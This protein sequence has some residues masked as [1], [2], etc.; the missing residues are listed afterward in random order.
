M[1]KI[2][3]TGASGFIARNIIATLLKNGHEVVGC[4]RN[5]SFVET[6]FPGMKTISADFFIDTDPKIWEARL[7]GVDVVINCVGVF[8]MPNPKDTWA[9]HYDTPKALFEAAESIGVKKIIHISALGI[10]HGKQPYSLSKLKIEDYLTHKNTVDSIILRPSVVYGSGSYG[11]SSLF[12][13]FAGMPFILPLPG[14]AKQQFQPI[15]IEDLARVVHESIDLPGKK[16]LALVGPETITLKSILNALR[17]WLGFKKAINLPIPFFSIRLLAKLGDR[18]T[19]S[20]VN[21]TAVEMMQ[22]DNI[23]TPEEVDE[24]KKSISFAPRGFSQAL[25]ETPS[26]VQDRWHARLYFAKPLLQYSLAFIWLW[27]AFAALFIS[28]HK[29]SYA[30]LSQAGITH[31]ASQI[32]LFYGSCL[33]NGALGCCIL[34]NYKLKLTGALSI[35]AML[36]YMI[37]VTF[38]LPMLWWDP[39]F[40]IAKNIPLIAATL[41][42]MG[43]ASNR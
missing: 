2:L 8:Q 39:L 14:K 18:F 33:I 21:T 19:D 30:L 27:V 17:A 35:A 40:S 7:A 20:P 31:S 42:M 9:A 12:R 41:I 28:S 5:I 16:L 6:I 25:L 37:F 36:F 10:Q 4:A 23:A 26:Q 13:G 34:L 29:E 32:I 1:S 22:Y 11:G 15:H 38:Y 3:V 24:L 43:L